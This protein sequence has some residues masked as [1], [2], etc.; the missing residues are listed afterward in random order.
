ME[1]EDGSLPLPPV[2]DVDSAVF[3]LLKNAIRA[4][5]TEPTLLLLFT[6]ALVLVGVLSLATV[7]SVVELVLVIEAVD[8]AAAA[9]VLF[10]IPA[11]LLEA[12]VLL[13]LL[14]FALREVNEFGVRD[15][16]LGFTVG[17][18]GFSSETPEFFS[19]FLQKFNT[20]GD[21]IS[22]INYL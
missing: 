13:R 5:M 15:F 11:F 8:T 14:L 21:S 16:G 1:E 3:G 12:K 10:S 2:G 7:E 4:A 9:L 6:V 22:T 18:T 20:I 17:T 19:K